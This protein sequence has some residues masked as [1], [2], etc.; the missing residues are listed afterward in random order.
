VF[1]RLLGKATV[2]ST[3]PVEVQSED[4]EASQSRLSSDQPITG[5]SEDLLARGPFVEAVAD[6]IRDV[7]R[8][9]GFVVGLSGPWGYGKTSVMRLLERELSDEVAAVIRFNPWLF[10]G[11]E[12]LVEHFFAEL[13]SQ[14]EETGAERLQGV[15]RALSAYGR[16][17]S[18][19]RYVPYAGEI[20]R[21]TSE[22]AAEG[23]RALEK[24]GAQPSVRERAA[25]L[26]MALKALKQPILVTVDD[27]DRLRDEEVVDVVR[28][29][30]LVGDFPNLIYVLAFDRPAIERSLGERNRVKGR[31]YLDKI[32][33]LSHE[34]PRIRA[35]DLSTVLRTSLEA[36][37]DEAG[38]YRVSGDRMTAVFW[39]TVRP[40][41]STIRDVRRYANVLPGALRLLGDEVDLADV[42]ALE[43]I[44]LFEPESFE[45]IVETR[46]L[47]TR[48]IRGAESTDREV[49]AAAIRAI[50]ETCA[51]EAHV[52]TIERIVR[53]L[54]PRSERY[55]GG[56]VYSDE[57]AA[58]WRTERRVASSSV[59]DIYIHKRLPPSEVPAVDV[60]RAV[61]TLSDG[62]AFE[63]LLVDLPDDRL[64]RLLVRLTE[65]E[66]RFPSSHPEGAITA[67]LR[68]RG[69]L[70]GEGGFFQFAPDIAASRLIYRLL[71]GLTPEA[72]EATVAA[73][74]Y[75]DLSGEL[76]VVRM[77]GHRKNVGQRLV[78]KSTAD[79]L[80]RNLVEKILAAPAEQIAAEREIGPL[81]L[82][83]RRSASA[84]LAEKL[85][86]WIDDDSFLVRLVGAH[87]LVSLAHTDE[88][89][90]IH[91]TVQLN[92]PAL[93]SL[94]SPKKL[95]P[96][97]AQIDPAWVSAN[98]EED[99]IVC[100]QQ[101]SRYK[102]DPEAAARDIARY[103]DDNEEEAEEAAN[104][105][106]H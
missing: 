70:R 94:V 23:G 35:E 33:H 34:L 81:V 53:T 87:K 20:F 17:V 16:I 46:D 42:M 75:P 104:R 66:Q 24:G 54:F 19:L 93:T 64:A 29:V 7:P 22:L 8:H 52:K 103:R 79:E 60:E 91:R 89:D 30:R 31:A 105:D 65:Y 51:S 59:L 40:L 36:T 63:A 47:L 90:G 55:L 57:I 39:S 73:I 27:I 95:G 72:I 4:E 50:Y 67:I 5:Y 58:E 84:E 18:P 74:D 92:W 77:V 71:R 69:R 37:L 80:E 99:T 68:Q 3:T 45:A 48:G 44:R 102:D 25:S 13:S 14:L 88:E 85:R 6:D 26:R 2:A 38:P 28:L 101:A 15:A 61:R 83:A 96:R 1:A 43:A 32:V 21:T 86:V 56:T 62:A 41:F 9:S 78:S 82:F 10:S 76:D 97:I 12:Q 11:T 49:A 98:F 100:W 106:A